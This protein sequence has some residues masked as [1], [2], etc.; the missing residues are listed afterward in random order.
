MI[1]L[2]FDSEFNSQNE[3]S[4]ILNNL[5]P[6]ERITYE[7][8]YIKENIA[9]FQFIRKRNYLK[10][11][12]SYKNC[13]NIAKKLEDNYKIRDSICN[14]AISL[15]YNGKLEQ[16]LEHLKLVYEQTLKDKNLHF[17][18]KSH[19]N[20]DMKN[21]LLDLKI[22]SNLTIA[23][24]SLNKLDDSISTFKTLCDILETKE[25]SEIQLNL[26]KS[27]LYNFFRV[28]SIITINENYKKKII[29][30]ENDIDKTEIHKNII[31]KIINAFHSYLKNN[32]IKIWINCLNEEIENLKILK[33]YNGLIFSI[34]NLESSIYIKSLNEKDNINKQSSLSKFSSLIKALVGEK[35][36][37]ENKIDSIL[38]CIKNKMEQAVYMYQTLYNLETKISMKLNKKEIIKTSSNN[39]KGLIDKNNINSIVFLKLLLKYANKYVNFNIS[40]STLSKQ[41]KNQIDITLKILSNEEI[42]HS[43]INLNNLSPE[44][45][46]ALIILFN[47]LLSIYSKCKLQNCFNLYRKT[48]LSLKIKERN[49]LIDEYIDS[50]Y[51]E[52]Q[53]GDSILKINLNSNGTKTHYYKLNY[54]RD[55]IQIF[56][57]DKDSKVDKE[58]FLYSLI[59]ITFGISSQNLK[60]K[61]KLLSNSDQP[62]L[63]MS[64]IFKEGSIDLFLNE[65]Q[66]KQWFYGLSR[67]LNIIGKDYKIISKCKFILNRCKMKM[68]N[69]L[70]T[71]S[72]KGLIKD[73]NSN[74]IIKNLN[75]NG[76]NKISFIKLFLLYNKIH[77]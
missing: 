77:K 40:D 47:N 58:I 3:S 10:A 42:D 43:S 29:I 41:I 26:I 75:T 55:S 8:N 61:I 70:I 50:C 14:Y 27:V 65:E 73:S 68:A 60:K 13:V 7:S 12:E 66:V 57:K 11:I 22:L 35:N 18:N 59:K 56:Q 9:A 28:D 33:D 23:Y 52:I 76:N 15:Y 16:S 31:R 46:K 34:F 1:N 19:N 30:D 2:Q 25:N 38:N 72:K 21:I 37:D 6:M 45:T 36:F 39:K 62:W 63:Y 17:T 71:Y 51:K 32:D 74:S 69:E 67:H 53:R 49:T 24:L 20:I 44:I 5:E 48:I 64:F 54:E 4:S